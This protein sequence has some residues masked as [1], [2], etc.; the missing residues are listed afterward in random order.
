MPMARVTSSKP[1]VR[2]QW[3]SRGQ[4]V[5]GDIFPFWFNSQIL[6]KDQ[7]SRIQS[8][9][10]RSFHTEY[11]VPV[12]E[13]IWIEGISDYRHLSFRQITQQLTATQ[14]AVVVF[15]FLKRLQWRRGKYDFHYFGHASLPMRATSAKNWGCK[16]WSKTF[17]SHVLYKGYPTSAVLRWDG[18]P[19][20]ATKRHS[21]RSDDS[22]KSYISQRGAFLNQIQWRHETLRVQ[23]STN[24][25]RR[26]LT[27]SFRTL[28]L[29][30]S[31]A[32]FMAFTTWKITLKTSV[33]TDLLCHSQFCT[34]S[35]GYLD[36]CWP[37]AFQGRR[38]WRE[39]LR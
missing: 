25:T 35:V 13:R 15:T 12:F 6:L 29:W 22:S 7:D 34:V 23:I 1:L 20:R 28:R 21:K 16:T 5:L 26:H 32:A 24:Q 38:G 2:G 19:A 31:K 10:K 33:Y 30:S 39:V 37:V 27:A 9:T 14:S 4:S 11:A 17:S 8:W 3:N 36:V 18:R